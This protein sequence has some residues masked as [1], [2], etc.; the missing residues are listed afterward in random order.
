MPQTKSSHN[1]DSR[2]PLASASQHNV[3]SRRLGRGLRRASRGTSWPAAWRRGTRSADARPRALGLARRGNACQLPAAA[4]CRGRTVLMQERCKLLAEFFVHGLLQERLAAD[5]AAEID[6]GGGAKRNRG[7]VE[8]KVC[9][10][11]LCGNTGTQ[12]RLC[13]AGLESHRVIGGVRV[14]CAADPPCRRKEWRRGWDSNPRAGVVARQLDFE[15]SA[16]RPGFATPPRSQT[17][18]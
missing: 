8:I 5:P 13:R 18:P 6:G 9:V 3:V 14:F 16:L 10:S 15:S 1:A 2:T 7:G 4:T 11:A 17:G 12:A